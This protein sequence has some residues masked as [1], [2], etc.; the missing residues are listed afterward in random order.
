MK[1]AWIVTKGAVR[2]FVVDQA[3]SFAAAIA[4]YTL[5]SIFPLTLFLVSVSGYVISPAQ[6]DSLVQ[7]VSDLLPNASTSAIYRQIH[8]VTNGRAALGIIGLVAALWSGSAVF[9]AIRSGLHAVWK[10]HNGRSWPAAKAI[11]LASVIGFGLMLTA[12]LA[13]SIL[14][15]SIGTRSEQQLTGPAAGAIGLGLR[16]ILYFLPGGAAFIAFWILYELA[17]PFTIQWRDTWLGALI[18]ALGYQAISIGF[19][20]YVRFFGRFD[21]VYGSL[22]AV[23]AFLFFAYLVGSLVLFGA[24]VIARRAELRGSSALHRIPEATTTPPRDRAVV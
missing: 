18:A 19:G 9:T 21:R 6:R 4:Y 17:S 16:A 8:T 15:T 7:H 3:G 2:G 22:G 24:E 1:T 5:F 23:I 13:G 11:D 20:F 10:T 12:S 14:L